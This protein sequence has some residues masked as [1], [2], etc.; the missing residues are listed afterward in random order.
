MIG[1]GLAVVGVAG[2]RKRP[3]RSRLAYVA[4]TIAIGM[5]PF[6]EIERRGVVRRVDDVEAAKGRRRADQ[7]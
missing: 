4:A 5:A 1:T 6:G 3:I 2:L 7:S